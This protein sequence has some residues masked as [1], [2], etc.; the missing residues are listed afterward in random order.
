MGCYHPIKAY[1]RWKKDPITK[2]REVK[3][4]V[5]LQEKILYEEILLPCGQCI[6]CRLDY[7][8]QWAIRIQKETTLWPQNWF[9]TLT[10][11]DEHVPWKSTVNKETG[12]VITGQTLIPE[13]MKKFIKDLRRH[14]KYHYNHDN[15]RF[16]G[17]GEY[18]EKSERPHLHICVFNLPLTKEQLELKFH[19]I[20]GDP[21][22]ICEEIEKIWG[23]GIVSLGAVTWES[24]AYVARYMVKKQK[25]ENA[26]AYYNSKAQEPEFTRMSR[27]PGIARDWY[28][29][30]KEE[31]YKNDE[32]FIPK[33]G[34]AIKLKPA[35]YFDRLYDIE[36][37]VKMEEIKT[38]RRKIAK[39]QQKLKLAKS[40][41]TLQDILKAAENRHK[42]RAKKLI[43]QLQ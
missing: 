39:K 14:W 28:E 4:S 42:E 12:E 24:A 15:I 21:I 11:D 33:K 3:F 2:K 37:P 10:Y 13:H 9:V 34:G 32:L 7:S 5:P 8:R 36:E 18:G 38:R 20:Q 35:K 16:F 25:G 26:E 30:H 19:N 23:K 40:T 41:G 1:Q 27:K 29:E 43:R 17:C 22:F 31:I 6:G